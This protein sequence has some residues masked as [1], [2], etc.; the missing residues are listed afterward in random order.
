MYVASYVTDSSVE[1][2]RDTANNAGYCEGSELDAALIAMAHGHA[3]AVSADPVQ[4]LHA[5]IT[6][7][8]DEVAD[9][10]ELEPDLV[11]DCMST[12]AVKVD[13]TGMLF[14]YASEVAALIEVPGEGDEEPT[15]IRAGIV[16]KKFEPVTTF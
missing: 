16:I 5:A 10:Y 1:D 14:E 7:L 3:V 11:R 12:V 15:I 13:V 6:A 8:V 2:I 4:A 9:G